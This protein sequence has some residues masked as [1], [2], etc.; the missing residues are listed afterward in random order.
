MQEEKPTV[1]ITTQDL[2]LSQVQELG[3]RMDRLE[4]RMDK[5]EEKFDENRREFNQKLEKQEEKI[6]KLA[7]KIDA[8]RRDLTG[9]SQHNQI[10]TATVSASLI[11]IVISLL[12]K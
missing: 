8:L 1:Q 5:L 12:V 6:E 11:A 7:D 3:K 4:K 10:L 2:I 9:G